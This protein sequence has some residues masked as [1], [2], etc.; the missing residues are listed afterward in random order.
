MAFTVCLPDRK[1]HLL[2]ETN[3]YCVCVCVYVSGCLGYKIFKIRAYDGVTSSRHHINPHHLYS[4]SVS[5]D[6]DTRA[7]VAGRMKRWGSNSNSSSP[8]R[9]LLHPSR[10]PHLN[11]FRPQF[12]AFFSGQM[13]VK[14]LDNHTAREAVI[15]CWLR[16]QRASL[17][18]ELKCIREGNLSVKSPRW[19]SARWFTNKCSI[20]LSLR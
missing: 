10:E 13:S 3:P 8:R 14:R 5:K 1:I 12:D 16:I 18:V 6:T 17:K 7:M 20:W 2:R 19:Q 15:T 4:P 11:R 9:R